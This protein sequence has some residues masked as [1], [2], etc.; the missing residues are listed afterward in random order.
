VQ[1][2]IF[3]AKRMV[4]QMIEENITTGVIDNFQLI[5]RSTVP[6]GSD[7]EKLERLSRYL[8]KV[9]NKKL[10]SF[11]VVAQESNN[12]V[13]GSTQLQKDAD[14]LISIESVY[15]QDESGGKKKRGRNKEDRKTVPGLRRLRVLPSR[16][17]REGSCVVAFDGARSTIGQIKTINVNGP[18]FLKDLETEGEVVD[19]YEKQDSDVQ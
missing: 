9:R 16:M 2:E 1:D 6:G 14:L 8:A 17:A 10:L 12:R 5:D 19:S 18:E 11:I 3:D 15:Q 4:E 7:R 13:F